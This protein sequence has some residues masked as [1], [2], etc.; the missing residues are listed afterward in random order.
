METTSSAPFRYDLNAAVVQPPTSWFSS[1][2]GGAGQAAPDDIR[3]VINLFKPH[4]TITANVLVRWRR[5]VT[6]MDGSN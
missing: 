6:F 5:R 1:A 3:P 2:A 4:F